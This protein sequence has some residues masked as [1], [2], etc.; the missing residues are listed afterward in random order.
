MRKQSFTTDAKG[1]TWIFRNNENPNLKNIDNP[2]QKNLEGIAT[3]FYVSN[4][5]QALD[6]K[7]L[8][9]AC[10]TYG[11]IVDAFIANKRSK[12]V[13]TCKCR[14]LIFNV[15]MLLHLNQ[16]TNRIPVKDDNIKPKLNPNSSY[17]EAPSNKPT[18]PVVI[19][20]K[21]KPTETTHSPVTERTITLND[22]D[23]INIE[24]SSTVLLLKRNEVES[25]SNMY[26][27]KIIV[28]VNG[29]M[30]DVQV[31]EIGT[32][33]INITDNTSDTSSHMDVNG[34]EKDDIYV[35]DYP[36]D[37]LSDSN[38]KLNELAQATKDE[39][40]HF[41]CS[42][43]TDLNQPREQVEEEVIKVS[44]TSDLSRPPGFEHV[45]RSSLSTSKCSTNFARHQKKDIKGL[46]DLPIGGR[47]YTWRNKSGT[48]LIKLNRFLISEG[49]SEDIPDIIVMAIDHMWSDHTPILLHA[50]KSDFG[51]S[52]FKFYNSWLNRDGFDDLIKSTWST[53]EAPNDGRILESHEKLRY[54]EKKIDDGSTSSS[55]RDKRIKLLQDIDKLEALDLILK[56]HI[57]WDVEGDENSKFFHRM[58]NNKRRSQALHDGVW[59]SDP[60]ISDPLLVKEAFLN[61]YKEKFQAHY[62]QVVFSLMIHYTSLTSL[63]R[64]SLE[65]HFSLDEIKTAVWDCDRNKS[66]GPNGFSF[67]FIKKYWDLIKTDILEFV[68][69]FFISGSMPQGADSSFF[70]LIPKTSNPIFI[71]DFRLISLIGIHYK[72][73]S[74]VLANRLSRVIGKVV[75]K[76]QSAFIY[77][78]QILDG[79]LIVSEVIQC[80]GFGSKW[81][82][83]I[84]ACLQSTRA[85]ILIN[86]SPTS[87]FSIKRGLQ[88]GEPLSPFLFI[89]DM[90]DLYGAMSNAVNSGLIQGIKLGSSNI[91]L[92]YLFYADDVVIT[93]EWNSE[94]LDNLIRVL[95]VFPS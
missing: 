72:I 8:W 85:Y 86:G 37:D 4:F 23:F 77:G 25:M 76:E 22:N 78:R 88:Q 62:S 3:S 19:H 74:K 46:I 43:A 27:K 2:Y 95:H 9:N 41:E 91:T 49:I 71:K 1:W 51:P 68:N 14:L 80:L 30:F 94:Y 64:N 57:K 89:L 11:R 32:W 67:A 34:L 13:F 58:I 54:I 5:P 59:I 17:R 70:M 60:R 48:K 36:N 75:S 16:P 38:D 39:K 66:P 50:M 81:R 29:E 12:R 10:A 31:H 73:I 61:Y 63:D 21:H 56:A 93:F 65:T 82:S 15:V 92:S 42:N 52:P 7:G 26:L 20:N 79:P 90:E 6:A 83:W 45:K 18:F 53:S 35:D 24:D 55:D 69:S 28:E 33:S 40:I 44:D 84:R 47:Y 87:E